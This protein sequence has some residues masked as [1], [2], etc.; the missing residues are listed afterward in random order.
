MPSAHSSDRSTGMAAW[1]ADEQG[2]LGLGQV[3][4]GVDFHEGLQP[5]RH[6][7]RL[8]QDVAAED[9]REHQQE[10]PELHALRGLHQHADHGGE[11]AHGEGDTDTSRQPMAAASGVV[12]M[13]NPRISPNPSVTTTTEMR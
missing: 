12:W 5:A 1:A 10:A 9:Q 4:D 3:G 11:P 2:A 13:R 6:L 7:R 8:R